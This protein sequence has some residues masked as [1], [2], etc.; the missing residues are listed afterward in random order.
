MNKVESSEDGNHICV[1]ISD[2]RRAM[3]M[4]HPERPDRPLMFYFDVIYPPGVSQLDVYL[5]TGRVLVDA[6]VKGY[7]AT[8]FAY[9]QTGSGKTF[10]MMGVLGTDLKGIIPR[11]IED[12]FDYIENL[13]PDHEGE[14]TVQIVMCE[15]YLEKLKDLFNPINDNLKVRE[16]PK[17]GIYLE[18]A[19]EQYCATVQE[20][21]DAMDSGFMNRATS[22]TRM[23]A[24][25][26]RSHCVVILKTTKR[27]GESKTEAKIKMVDL[28]GSEKTRKTQATG[29]RLEEA[30]L[31]NASLT[32]LSQVLVC[33]TEG[34]FIPYRN[35]KL[36]RLL[37]DALGGNSKTSLI[38]AA[39]PCSYNCEETL[40]SM[41]FGT[42]A[43]KVKNTAKV[44]EELSM[45]QYKKLCHEQ[46]RVISKLEYDNAILKLK[47]D[48]MSE[49]ITGHGGDVEDIT[50]DCKI[51]EEE[52][53]EEDLSKVQM[54]FNNEVSAEV[55]VIDKKTGKVSA[56]TVFETSFSAGK[57]KK[58]K[59]GKA[60]DKARERM[61]LAGH[62]LQIGDIDGFRA[63]GFGDGGGGASAEELED[64]IAD[65]KAELRGEESRADQLE[66]ELEKVT[67]EL[68]SSR[69]K[70][71]ELN[72]KL[73][74]YR[75]YKQKVEFLEREMEMN[76]SAA[77]VAIEIDDGDAGSA[78]VDEEWLNTPIG[79]CDQQWVAEAQ[80]KLRF[81]SKQMMKKDSIIKRLQN[82]SS[83]VM[84][85]E[86]LMALASNNDAAK[87]GA[88]KKILDAQRQLSGKLKEKEE[89]V[90]KAKRAVAMLQQRDKFNQELKKNWQTRLKQMEQAVLLCSQIHGRDRKKFAAELAEKEE[91][92]QKLKAYVQKTNEMRAKQQK[93]MGGASNR[94][95]MPINRKGARGRGGPKKKKRP[96]K[97]AS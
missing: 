70:V 19:V 4:V 62:L 12:T 80:K 47:Y 44:N 49:W 35:S 68:D 14:Y 52:E 36:T 96:A 67:D 78:L 30:K 45:D 25:S 42:R 97:A 87:Q 50:K 39:S 86:T 63:L 53:G 17:L 6:C 46:K 88:L 21:L 66:D 18:D 2:C 38:V 3:K 90:D 26:S 32:A 31:I 7:N 58:G 95:M 51:V 61:Q 24:E 27:V 33:L 43:K 41:R 28:A 1:K 37:Q 5:Y 11:I 40:G 92:I 72:S 55:C 74:E 93:T 84:D 59:K 64:Q 56:G 89:E 85:E 8:I 54:D 23:N 9:G 48:V 29:Q 60:K 81:M 79:S 65:L 82:A 71:A 16:D 20:V 10:S 75:F 22:A 83:S 34:G 77:P 91:Q 94:M 15:I 69:D 13:P 57:G 73:A 76:K